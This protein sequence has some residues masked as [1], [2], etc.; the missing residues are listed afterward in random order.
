MS[1]DPLAYYAHPGPLST[2][3]DPAVNA[4]LLAGLP[5]EIPALVECVQGNLLHIFW[6]ERYGVKL[7]N[8]QKGGVQVRTAAERLR[9]IHAANPA[10]LSV[11]R[12][13]DQRSVGNCRDFTLLTVSLLRRQ[14]I[15][16]RSR[17]GFGTYFLPDHYEDHWVAEYWDGGRWVQ[18]DAQLDRLQQDALKIDFDPLD[19][20]HDRFLNGGRAWK[21]CREE[22]VDPE[23]FGIFDMHGLWFV[24]G[25]L[26]RDLAALNK[27]ELLPWDCWGVLLEDHYTASEEALALL[28]RA[29]AMALVDNTQF[30][31]MQALYAG[32]DRLRV[33]PVIASFPTGPTPVQI[34]LAD[35]PGFALG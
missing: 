33:P 27:M 12:P 2:L 28:D 29:A 8:E 4:D 20:P 11:A 34:T 5:S 21:L 23:K 6:A 9:R 16:A 14:G 30:D 13:P 7:T 35:E 22:G 15:P 10:P 31:A 1:P 18:V 25:D 19:V 32:S 24:A 26:L 17:C 3:S